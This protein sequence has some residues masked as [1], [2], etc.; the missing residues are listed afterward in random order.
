MRF[1]HFGPRR[2]IYRRLS[3]GEV[4]AHPPISAG[5]DHVVAEARRPLFGEIVA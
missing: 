2:Q 4:I 5:E 1:I 3:L